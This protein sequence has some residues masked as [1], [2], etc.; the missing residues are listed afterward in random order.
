M[1]RLNI[2]IVTILF[3]LTTTGCAQQAER[4]STEKANAWYASQKW[5]VGI[6]YVTATAINQFEMWQEETFDPKTMELE[7]GRAGELGFNTVRI[8]LHDMVWEADPA[9]FKQRLDTFLGI[10]QKHGMRAIV[11]FFTNGGRFESPKLGVQ[12]ASV[13]GVHNSQWI[14][15][16]GAPS[17]NDPSTYPRLERYVKDVMTTFKADDRILLWCLYNEPENFKQKAYN[18]FELFDRQW[19]L[20]TAGSIEHYNSCT[21]GWGS[22]GNLWG[23]T[24]RSRPTVTVYVHPAR[25]TCEFLER[26]DTFT[27]SFYPPEYRRALGYIGSHSGRD[28]D[29]AAAAGL[30]PVA[31]GQGV[32]YG[33]EP[34]LPVQKALPAPVHH[35]GSRAGGA[36]ILRLD[37]AGLP[38]LSRRLA[39][40][41]C[42]RGRDHRRD[43]Q[44][45][46]AKQEN[47]V[48]KT[49][50][51]FLQYRGTYASGLKSDFGWWHSGQMKSSGMSAP[52]YT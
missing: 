40:A 48:A 45:L 31:F 46:S 8:F 23:P 30:T 18:V 42:V 36:G 12:P 17:V 37:A 22:L 9:G 20:V 16:P 19:A 3:L 4:W 11:T 39:A 21:V 15:S 25:Y 34:D 29:K 50:T 38:R 51:S 1:N 14:Q 47:D 35:R 52:S 26:G 44:A 41:H 6:N 5:P 28:G 10:C 49:V 33:V 2:L 24:G 43:R 27:V 32:T 7:L 13:Q